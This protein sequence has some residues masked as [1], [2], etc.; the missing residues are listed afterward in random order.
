M[1]QACTRLAG[2]MR[3]V[4]ECAEGM[5]VPAGVPASRAPTVLCVDPVRLSDSVSHSLSHRNIN[6]THCR[7]REP[8]TQT[9]TDVKSR[10]SCRGHAGVSKGSQDESLQIKKSPG[11]NC[12]QG[13]QGEFP[14]DKGIPNPTY[15]LWGR[16]GPAKTG[17]RRPSLTVRHASGADNHVP[18][19]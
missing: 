15:S 2:R 5:G 16:S 8:H 14:V 17:R 4:R 12:N 11:A 3:H 6:R 7:R 13:L 18:K 19:E 10:V 1:F 9:R